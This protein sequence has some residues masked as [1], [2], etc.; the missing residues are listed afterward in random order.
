MPGRGTS[1]I[2]YNILRH[3]LFNLRQKSVL[4]LSLKRLIEADFP[5]GS[6]CLY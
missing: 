3:F 1:A 4:S 5:T 6:R 2:Q